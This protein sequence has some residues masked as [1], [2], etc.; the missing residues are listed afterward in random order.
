MIAVV[1]VLVIVAVALGIGMMGGDDAQPTGSAANPTIA[2]EGAEQQALSIVDVRSGTGTTLTVPSSA[3]E[4]DVSLD[5]SMVA[6][7]DLDENGDAQVFV[8]DADGS[9][10][11][12]LTGGEGA[13]A[14]PTRPARS[15]PPTAP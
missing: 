9:N 10:A 5:G 7:I 12:R 1:A 15:G 6:Y 3:S 8:M 4:F 11:K 13:S 2:P 14:M